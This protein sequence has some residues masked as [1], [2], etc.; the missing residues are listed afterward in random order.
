MNHSRQSQNQPDSGRQFPDADGFY[1]S[2]P[3][4]T[5]WAGYLKNRLKDAL[6]PL[7]QERDDRL[8]AL[9]EAQRN[10]DWQWSASRAEHLDNVCGWEREELERHIFWNDPE[11]MTRLGRLIRA[12]H[13]DGEE[14]VKAGLRPE[15]MH[16]FGQAAELASAKRF[17][18]RGVRIRD[19]SFLEGLTQLKELDLWDNDIEDL[20]PLASLTG[21]RDLWLPYNLI[22]DLSPLANLDKLVGLKIYGNQITSLEPLRGLTNLNTLDLRNNPLEPGTLA[23]LRKCKRLGM[24]NL[25]KTGLNNIKDLEFCRAHVLELYE[26]PNLTGLEVIST[27]KRLCCLY[28]DTEVARQYDVQAL[29]PQLIEYAELDGL[30]LYVWPE[31]YYN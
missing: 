8:A 16:L 11:E 24:L 4:P 6:R 9:R 15:E 29:A 18:Q 13:T 20:A 12:I 17:Q 25:S 14:A 30:S 28:I 2:G 10:P 19:L 3:S 27:M 31:K 21:L 22:S 7:P 23:C 26:N 1:Y 5:V